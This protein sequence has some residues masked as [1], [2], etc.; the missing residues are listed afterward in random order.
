MAYL[1]DNT[2]I[3]CTHRTILFDIDRTIFDTNK[4]IELIRFDLMNLLS[5]DN[6]I[7]K[8]IEDDYLRE[9]SRESFFSPYKYSKYLSLKFNI[10]TSVFF[11]KLFLKKEQYA[12]SLFSDTLSTFNH[13]KMKNIA[14]GIFSEGNL[15]FQKLKIE[16]S[17]VSNF[18]SFDKI[19][20]FNNKLSSTSLSK[21]PQDV[22]IVDDK[23]SVAEKLLKRGYKSV[24]INRNSRKRHYLI[25]TI[26]SLS[27]LK[28]LHDCRAHR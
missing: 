20:I 27:D 8:K 14:L 16:S 26:F 23:L 6:R 4:F 9:I 1:I 25:P 10:S 19:F 28:W 24:W 5:C 21:L 7:A 18:F 22:L 17:G 13:L 3:I 15:S 2:N 12:E 11:K